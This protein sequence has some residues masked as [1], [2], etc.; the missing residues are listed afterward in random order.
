MEILTKAEI[1]SRYDAE[2]A[3]GLIEAGFIAYS[4]GQVQLPPVQHF[5]FATANGD[6]CVKSGY[7]EGDDVFAVKVASGFYDNGKRGLSSNQ[8]LIV[9]FSALTGEP[10]ALLLDEGLL[11]ALRTALAGQIAAR[12]LAPTRVHGIGVLGTGEQAR[13]QLEALQQ[14][15]DCKT[16]HVW[17]RSL[18][19][20]DAFREAMH[21]RMKGFVF[22]PTL[23]AEEVARACNLIVSTTPS[24]TPILHADWIMPG[25]HITAVG[26]DAQGKQELATA[27]VAKADVIVVDS[28]IQCEGFGEVSHARRAGLIRA[29]Q[30]IELGALLCKEASGRQNDRQVTIADLT[31]LAIQD[32]QIAKSIL[33]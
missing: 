20:L 9:V 8:G 11:T 22:H 30:L 28:R 16:V 18:A 17:G 14:V 29:D 19:S 24:T 33:R 5:A 21:V 4:R 1:E 23:D 32:V 26:A 3:R 15:T 2:K 6:A 12:M 31:G 7:L 10:R 13:R 25:T 27:L